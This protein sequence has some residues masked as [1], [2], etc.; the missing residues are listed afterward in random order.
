M[1][2]H[3]A[4]SLQTLHL[5]FPQLGQCALKTLKEKGRAE[6]NKA[7]RV[8]DSR[9]QGRRGEQG[10]WVP[11]GAMEPTAKPMEEAVKDSRHVIAMNRTNLQP[12]QMQIQDWSEVV[13]PE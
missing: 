11:V 5:R 6:N 3:S 8:G 2:I 9:G 1:K 13:Q 10:P 7:W 4:M 12:R